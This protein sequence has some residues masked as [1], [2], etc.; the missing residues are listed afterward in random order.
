MQQGARAGGRD[1]MCSTGG[2]GL[3]SRS[4]G[5][6]GLDSGSQGGWDWGNPTVQRSLGSHAISR[7]VTSMYY[8][9]IGTY[10]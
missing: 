4:Q 2:Q 1:C 6:A 9:M 7:W 5:T 8:K 10:A 3:D